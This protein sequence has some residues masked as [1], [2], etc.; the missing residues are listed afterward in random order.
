MNSLLIFAI[1]NNK[2]FLFFIGK[3]Q[4]RDVDW[5]DSV[6]EERSLWYTMLERP[7]TWVDGSLLLRS[8][9]QSRRIV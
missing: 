4:G 6:G 1:T 2:V 7:N 8:N 5:M 3:Y 9:M